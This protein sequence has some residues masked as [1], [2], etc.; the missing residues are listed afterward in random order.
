M[1]R[2][3]LGKWRQKLNELQYDRQSGN[4]C[5]AWERLAGEEVKAGNYMRQIKTEGGGEEEKYEKVFPVEINAQDVIDA[6]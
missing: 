2:K 6:I 1:S 5:A 3:T 4:S